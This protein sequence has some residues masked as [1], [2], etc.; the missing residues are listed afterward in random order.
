[1]T[2]QALYV[3]RRMKANET[4]V[5]RIEAAMGKDDALRRVQPTTVPRHR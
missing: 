4:L 3:A 5:E 2:G 1:M